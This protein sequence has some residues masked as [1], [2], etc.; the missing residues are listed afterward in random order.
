MTRR[1]LRVLI[2][3][4]KLSGGPRD[5]CYRYTSELLRAILGLGQGRRQGFELYCYIHGKVFELSSLA[6]M[7]QAGRQLD[8][9]PLRRFRN[10]ITAQVA[11]ARQDIAGR[12]R[13]V[14]SGSTLDRIKQLDRKSGLTR[15][16]E[17]AHQGKSIEASSFD[18]VH[19]SLPQAYRCLQPSSRTSLLVTIHDCTHRNF[20]TFHLEQNV[21]AAENGIQFALERDAY[22]LANSE[23]TRQ[24]FIS[25]YGVSKD[26]VTVTPLAV[27]RSRFT[28]NTDPEEIHRIRLKYNLP[29]RPYFLALSTL[30]PRK[31]LLNTARAFVALRR[32]QPDTDI[33]L[34]IAGKEGWKFGELLSDQSARD[35]R[36]FFTGYVDDEDLPILYSGALALSFV[37]FY[38]GFGLPALEAMSCG[39]PVVYGDRGAL[40]EVVGEAGLPADPNDVS[41][42]RTKLLRFINEPRL[43]EALGREAVR[44]AGH[45]SWARTAETTL[46]VYA[47]IGRDL[48]SG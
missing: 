29:Q 48:Q 12:L 31:N 25:Q 41:D 22:F 8:D 6:S 11:L 26:R 2:E 21:R 15:Q 19:L 9:R 10:M 40:P 43:G 17:D 38:E 3:A 32:M 20:P 1:P 24:D 34:V 44:R 37:S 13:K 7:I 36:I 16:L 5:G 47:A 46:E 39:L 28:R 4:T 35:D 14:V 42:I 27:D 18:L 45:Y 30:E 33:A 23:T